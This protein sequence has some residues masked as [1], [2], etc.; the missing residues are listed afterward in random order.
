MPR[1]I[2]SHIH[3]F[4]TADLP[5]LSWMTADSSLNAAHSQSEYTRSSSYDVSG[6]IFVE[7]DRSFPLPLTVS[8]STLQHPLKEISYALS[9]YTSSATPALLGMIPFAPVPLGSAGM[10]KW[11][12]LVLTLGRRETVEGMVRGVRYLVQDK[13]RRTLTE[14]GFVDGVRWVLERGWVFELGVDVRSGGM[15]QLEEAVEVMRELPGDGWV[16][17]GGLLYVVDE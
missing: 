7:T 16:V 5:H 8:P 10:R 13:P 14:A 6:Y 11:W 9:L 2:D 17:I 15:W 1:I 3:L 12:E 4:T